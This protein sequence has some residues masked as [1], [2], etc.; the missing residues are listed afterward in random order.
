MYMLAPCCRSRGRAGEQ[1]K[2]GW[3]HL[4]IQCYIIQSTNTIY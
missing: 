3:A 1:E 4:L 2:G